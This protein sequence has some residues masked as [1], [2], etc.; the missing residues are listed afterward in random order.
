WCACWCACGHGCRRPRTCG[1][2]R[3]IAIYYYGPVNAQPRLQ[4]RRI[5][6]KLSKRPRILLNAHGGR[7][8]VLA[9]LSINEVHTP[10]GRLVQTQLEVYRVV[11][12]SK[13]QGAPLDIENA[14]RA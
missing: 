9:H 5:A 10:G 2:G 4:T 11:L 12:A 3:G 7:T 14:V 1:R 13:G 8:A 6:R